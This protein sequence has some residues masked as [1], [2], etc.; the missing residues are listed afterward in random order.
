M[1]TFIKTK[2]EVL[3]LLFTINI[4]YMLPPYIVPDHNNVVNHLY[5]KAL[6][7]TEQLSHIQFDGKITKCSSLETKAVW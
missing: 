6:C 7:K 4:I 5:P 1:H 2:Y 3:V